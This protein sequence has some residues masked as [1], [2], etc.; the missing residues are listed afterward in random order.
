MTHEDEMDFLQAIRQFGPIKIIHNTFGDEAKMEINTLQLVGSVAN[1]ANLS[2]LNPS[3]NTSLKR[4][5]Y[6]GQSYYCVDLNES[7]VVQFNRCKPVQT[8]LANGR[9]WFDENCSTGKKSNAFLIW[10]TSLLKWIQKNYHKN[11]AGHFVAP[12][13]LELEKTGK[14]QLGPSSE[15]TISLEERKRLLGL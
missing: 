11:A 4:D 9:L 7:E 8:W 10:A 1:D 2:L 13:A 15:P 14:L 5:F 3:I 6:Q 12:R